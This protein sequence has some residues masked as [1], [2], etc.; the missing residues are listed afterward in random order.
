M[1]DSE[2]VGLIEVSRAIQQCP[3]VRSLI[4]TVLS[5]VED[6]LFVDV[7]LI[8]STSEGFEAW[9]LDRSGTQAPGASAVDLAV[10][11]GEQLFHAVSGTPTVGDFAFLLDGRIVIPVQNQNSPKWLVV[12]RAPDLRRFLPEATRRLKFVFA[13]ADYAMLNLKRYEDMKVDHERYQRMTEDLLQSR[14]TLEEGQRLSKTG[15]WRWDLDSGRIDWSAETYRIYGS[16]PAD[17]PWTQDR[18]LAQVHPDDRPIVEQSSRAVL[19]GTDFVDDEYRIVLSDGRIK[20]LRSRAATKTV[21]DRLVEV[22]GFATDVT[23]EKLAQ[24]RAAA[25]QEEAVRA[26]RLSTVGIISASIAHDL[27]QPLVAS[28]ANIAAAKQWLARREPDLGEISE[29]LDRAEANSQ[30]A[31]ELVKSVRDIVNNKG[32]S[33]TTFDLRSLTEETRFILLDDLKKERIMLTID[34]DSGPV[35]AYADRSKIQQVMLNLVNNAVQAL[36]SSDVQRRAIDV[37]LTRPSQEWFRVVVSDNGPGISQENSERLFSRMFTTKN[38]GMGLGLSICRSIVEL[39]GGTLSYNPA[40][41]RG[42]IFAFDI[43]AA[44]NP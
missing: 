2:F 11:I 44:P 35:D 14:I 40:P 4:A 32:L 3:D 33:P 24:E 43:P 6:T 12:L 19:E 17:G 31:R 21:G 20:Y 13:Q 9:S 29:C 37:A 27:S 42:A 30:R 38:D 41:A 28:L 16:D 34:C 5:L 10:A 8:A 39:H 18:F 7:T 25:L 22:V 36:R 23:A 15:S 26:A 1:G